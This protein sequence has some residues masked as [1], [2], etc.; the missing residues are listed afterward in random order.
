MKPSIP[1]RVINLDRSVDRLALMANQLDTLNL[2]WDRLSAVAPTQD[3]ALLHP[4]YDGI[5]A[6]ALFGRDLAP[7]EIGCFLSHIVALRSFVESKSP[8]FIVLEDDTI[9]CRSSIDGIESVLEFLEQSFEGEWHC[10]NLSSSYRKR[11]CQL[12]IFNGFNL[13]RA[14]YFPL[15]TSALLWSQSGAQ[16][17]LASVEANGIYSPV[18]NQIRDFL[19]RYGIGLFTDPCLVGLAKSGS[20][21]NRVSKSYMNE[22]HFGLGYM[23]QKAPLYLAAALRRATKT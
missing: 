2:S 23:R 1:I 12:E 3:Q 17:F 18:D 7:G 8:T 15:L 19:T 4:L 14:Y 22:S 9:V 20:T 16:A 6:R 10:I 21:I 5:R 13:Y 11:R